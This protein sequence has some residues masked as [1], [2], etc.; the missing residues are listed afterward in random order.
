MDKTEK[1]LQSFLVL[2]GYTSAVPHD[3]EHKM[4]HL[5]HLLDA[6]DEK[7]VISYYG[8]FGRDRQ[9]LDDIARR[10]GISPEDMM[11]RIDASIRKIAI[12]PEWQMMKGGN[13]CY[14]GK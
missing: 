5:L 3:I 8:L 10:R 12:T 1:E 2:M 14:T 13:K 7:A 6:D 4:E 11:A 9:A